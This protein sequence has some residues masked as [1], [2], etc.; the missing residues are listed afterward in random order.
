M[1]LY[2]Y[3]KYIIYINININVNKLKLD[4]PP[5]N[6]DWAGIESIILTGSGFFLLTLKKV[7]ILKSLRS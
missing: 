2:I 3:Y 5:I 6:K 4:I 7:I 1:T